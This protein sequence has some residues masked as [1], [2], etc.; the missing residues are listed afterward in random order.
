MKRTLE[1]TL[2]DDAKTVDVDGR[3]QFSTVELLGISK[4][5][6]ILGTLHVL[7]TFKAN[8]VEE[9]RRVI[10]EELTAALQ[11]ATRLIESGILLPTATPGEKGEGE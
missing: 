10:R 6:E 9:F 4:H 3:T 8:N 7:N 1:I 2:D 11:E 5:L